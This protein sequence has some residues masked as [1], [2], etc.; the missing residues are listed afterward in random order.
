[1]DIAS[2]ARAAGLQE[3]RIRENFEPMIKSFTMAAALGVLAT[4]AV[5]TL[6]PAPASAQPRHWFF[7]HYRDFESTARLA[8]RWRRF[9]APPRFDF[10]PAQRRPFIYEEE[11]YESDDEPVYEAGPTYIV[12]PTAPRPLYA[13]GVTVDDLSAEANPGPYRA[14]R[15]YRG[16]AASART[17]ALPPVGE[18]TQGRRSAST[19][20]V[21]VSPLPS[22]NAKPRATRPART[23]G[24][25]SRKAITC[26]GGKKIVAGFGFTDIKATRCSGR[27]YA[28][29]AKRD[30][31]PFEIEVSSASGELK[32]VKRR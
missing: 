22:A 17:A 16:P 12:P 15:S 13:P 29:N 14:R 20:P 24:K 11:V 18:P 19:A 4:T 1:M 9:Q 5:P 26:Q 7:D 30:G 8:R 6:A 25:R 27:L 23:Q 28:F 3:N 2:L 21:A 10:D 32:K 31:K